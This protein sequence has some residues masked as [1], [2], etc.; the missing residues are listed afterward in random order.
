MENSAKIIWASPQSLTR[1]GIIAL[2]DQEPDFTF[3]EIVSEQADMVNV[4]AAQPTVNLLIVD[5]LFLTEQH[6][7]L[8]AIKEI[9]PLVKVLVLSGTEHNEDIL[10]LMKSGADGYIINEANKD[11]LI[12]AIKHILAGNTYIC[13]ALYIQVLES[14]AALDKEKEGTAVE[15]SAR[16][17]QIL[18]LILE[19]YSNQEIAYQLFTN[20]RTILKHRENLLHK[21][22]APDIGT[23]IR[24]ALQQGV[25]S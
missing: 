3:A 25:L 18:K 16:E 9:A 8:T 23:V 7:L 20:K 12:F 14:I 10:D 5:H 24:M 11:E 15:F 21:T 1:D 2:L 19:G 4:I 22:G 13:T 17:E 6:Q